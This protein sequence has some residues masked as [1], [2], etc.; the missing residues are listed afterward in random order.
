MLTVHDQGEESLLDSVG[1]TLR[2]GVH[3]QAMQPAGQRLGGLR[4]C[5]VPG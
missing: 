3:R 4:R 2:E 5:L 1:L